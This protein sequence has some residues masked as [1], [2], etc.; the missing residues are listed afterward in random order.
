MRAVSLLCT[1]AL[2]AFLLSLTVLPATAAATA[3]QAEIDDAVASAVDYLRAQQKP[4]L[5]EEPDIGAIPGFGGDWATSALAAAGVHAADLRSAPGNPSLQ[6]FLLGEYT[7][8]TW[9]EDPPGGSASDYARSTL[10]TAAGGL[11]PARLSATSNQPAQ[12]AGRWN[13]TTGSFG[14]PSSYTTAFAI[15]ALRTT[16]LPGWALEPTISYLRRNQHDD[17]GW[18]FGAATTPPAQAEPSES[19]MT[20]AAIAALCE[21]GVPAY[22]P[23]VA[24]ALAYL[25]GLLVEETGAIHYAFGDSSDATAWAISGLNACGIDPQSPAWTTGAGKTPVDHLLSLQLSSGDG[26]GGFGYMDTTEASL[27]STQDALRALAGGVFG[28]APPARLDPSQPRIRPVPAVS[29][30]TPV[31]HLIAIGRGGGNVRICKVTAPAEAPLPQV[32]AAAQVAS[33]PAGCVNSFAVDAGEVVAINGISP[34]NEDEAWLLRLDRG[35]EAVAGEQPVGFGDVVSLRLGQSPSSLQGPAGES[36]PAGS[37][38]PAGSAGKQGKRGGKGSR[39][40][41]GPQGKPGRN[42]TI[43]CKVR[44]R[45]SGKQRI[46]CSVKYDR[47]GRR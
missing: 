16:P 43:A 2:C 36:G 13:A 26:A 3:T 20:G 10:L 35:A 42:A 24:D 18:N 1:S 29:S 12:L 15:L 22:D 32:L 21:A 28:A 25:R 8:P 38:G 19:D 45:A 14:E 37:P 34:E 39:G 17:G 40:E 5:P 27:Y 31:P 6:E 9:D 4:E 47:R 23:D 7:L 41:R 33:R 11:D 46:R 44:K 30:G